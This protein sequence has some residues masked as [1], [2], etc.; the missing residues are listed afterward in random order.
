[1][2]VYNGELIAG[3]FIAGSGHIAHWNGTIWQPL[4]LGLD[5]SVSSLVVY[6][7]KLIVGGDFNQA[8]GLSAHA[9]ARWDGANWRSVG[10]GMT[11]AWGSYAWVAALV[12]YND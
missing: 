9:I 12:E 4:G 6:D 10:D 3:G 7:G 1:M 11:A 5:A 2:A 8:G